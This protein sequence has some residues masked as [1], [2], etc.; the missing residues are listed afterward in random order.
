MCLSDRRDP[1]PSTT[2]PPFSVS[3][4]LA[5]ETETRSPFAT[6]VREI[7]VDTASETILGTPGDQRYS[8][9][10]LPRPSPL[11]APPPPRSIHT[12]H[13]VDVGTSNYPST[14]EQSGVGFLMTRVCGEICSRRMDDL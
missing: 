13:Q 8:T 2:H 14:T 12:D 10:S 3:V 7:V 9:S 6:D 5:R 11:G 1:L 4:A